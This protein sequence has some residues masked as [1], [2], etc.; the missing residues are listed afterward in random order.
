MASFVPGS[1]ALFLT[2]TVAMLVFPSDGAIEALF[3]SPTR[4]PFA[5]TGYPARAGTRPESAT[6]AIRS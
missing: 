5:N 3:T 2:Y 4:S 6:P 1:A